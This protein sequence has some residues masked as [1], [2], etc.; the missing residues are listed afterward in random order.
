M[1]SVTVK[2]LIQYTG[3]TKLEHIT[4]PA[5][6]NS[7]KTFCEKFENDNSGVMKAEIKGS[8]PHKSYDDPSDLEDVISIRFKDSEDKR[9]ATAHVHKDGSSKVIRW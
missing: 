1:F 4:D 6:Y 3:K 7:V 5:W 8:H 9:V 2:R